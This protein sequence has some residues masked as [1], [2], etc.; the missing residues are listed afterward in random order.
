MLRKRFLSVNSLITTI[1]TANVLFSIG[2]I[3]TAQF[4]T[5]NRSMK[6]LSNDSMGGRG[7]TYIPQSGEYSN[8]VL[9]FHGLGDTADGWASMMVARFLKNNIYRK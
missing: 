4:S 9:W 6:R 3:A 5:T 1:F 7:V 2:T 8:V